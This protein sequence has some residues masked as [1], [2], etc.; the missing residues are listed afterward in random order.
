M[1][2]IIGK[3]VCCRYLILT[4]CIFCNILYHLV[5]ESYTVIIFCFAVLD[6]SQFHRHK[7]TSQIGV[8]PFQNRF[9][10]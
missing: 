9:G 8:C 5:I 2:G 6:D 3:E 10:K 7:N 4:V 1:E